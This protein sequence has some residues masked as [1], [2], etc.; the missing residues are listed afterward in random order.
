MLTE[1]KTG[2]N[3]H[4]TLHVFRAWLSIDCLQIA[5][6]LLLVLNS[7]IMVHCRFHKAASKENVHVH[8]HVFSASG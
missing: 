3:T 6:Q 5:L 1:C 2:R 4:Q 8:F 7:A